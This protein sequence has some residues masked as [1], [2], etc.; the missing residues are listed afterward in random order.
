MLLP[1][2]PVAFVVVAVVIIQ[3]PV[4][5]PLVFEVLPEVLILVRPLINAE[6]WFKVVL[7][8]SRVDISVR[9]IPDSFAMAL[10]L[11]KISFEN[12]P[13]VPNILSIPFW[14]AIWVAT[15]VFIPILKFF[16]SFPVHQILHKLPFIPV[17]V[18]EH[19]HSKALRLPLLPFT[20]VTIAVYP[21]PNPRTVLVSG[22]PLSI[23]LFAI[24]PLKSAFAVR[25]AVGILPLKSWFIWE[26][27]VSFAMFHI[28]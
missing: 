6:P 27:F 26:N 22:L 25:L 11:Q 1:I 4:P 21:S 23:V 28:V 12:R 19:M 9:L 16:M 20:H 5:I 3:L 18:A 15:Y 7:I 13:V 2:Q 14:F 10:P 17:S 8:I 24:C